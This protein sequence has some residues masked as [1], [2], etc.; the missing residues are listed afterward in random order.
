M[1]NGSVDNKTFLGRR[2]AG[3]WINTVQCVMGSRPHKPSFVV[4]DIGQS[5]GIILAKWFRA[6][7][8]LTF[9]E[10]ILSQAVRFPRMSVY[11]HV[12][13]SQGEAYG[14]NVTVEQLRQVQRMAD[15]NQFL[16]DLRRGGCRVIAL[17]RRDVLRHAIATLKTYSVNC[18]FDTTEP[19]RSNNKVTVDVSELLACLK[20]LDNQRI[21]A[22][23]ILQNIS[24][25]SLTYEDD[26]MDLNNHAATAKRLSDFLEIP[27][28]EPVGEPL[29]LV[30]QQLADIVINYDE[31]CQSLEKSDYAYLLTSNRY[32]LTV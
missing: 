5:G 15:P 19:A 28:I 13:Q 10:D 2:L 12:R 17:H 30:H 21:E 6:H 22:N 8:K 11:Q 20:Y 14:F 26:L 3:S 23:A 27:Q 31:M 24:H 9:Q 32:L 18:R 4:F 1:S 25:I 29:K 16:Q 7:S